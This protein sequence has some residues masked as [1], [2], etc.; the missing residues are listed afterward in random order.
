MMAHGDGRILERERNERSLK[1]LSEYLAAARAPGSADDDGGG[2]PAAAPPSTHHLPFRFVFFV[3]E[4][5]EDGGGLSG[6]APDDDEQAGAAAARP[7]RRVELTLPPPE[8]G[9]GRAGALSPAARRA[10]RRLLAAC[11]VPEPP[12]DAPDDERRRGQVDEEGQEEEGSSAG[13]EPGQG[14]AEWLPLAAEAARRG[15]G[16]GGNGGAPLAGPTAGPDP[17]VRVAN[18]RGA[19]RL[20]RGAAVSFCPRLRASAPPARQAALLH[21]LIEVLRR[22]DEAAAA[23]AEQEDDGG[24]AGSGDHNGLLDLRGLRIVLSASSGPGGLDG[25]GTVWLDAREAAAIEARVFGGGRERGEATPSQQAVAA[26]EALESWGDMLAGIDAEHA[27]GL[28]A[29]ADALRGLEASVARAVGVA[30]VVP[31]AGVA[32]SGGEGVS[33]SYRAFLERLAAHASASGPAQVPVSDVPL[34]VVGA[35][36]GGRDDSSSSS[37]SSAAVGVPLDASPQQAYALL[38][39]QG[40]AAAERRRK[41]AQERAARADLDLRA[42]RA[43]GL[44]RLLRDPC[45]PPTQADAGVRRLLRLREAVASGSP[46]LASALEGMSVRVSDA[47]RYAGTEGSEGSSAVVDVAWD[48]RL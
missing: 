25:A 30:A 33:P 11:G 10:L 6:V 4:E 38:A 32:F 3:P 22:E 2:D 44:R 41:D 28:R 19:L 23:L 35:V 37:S 34:V 8:R 5:E 17:S 39:A 12:A 9:R 43:L 31:A 20:S 18:L 14:L 42:R 46:S 26:D 15:G 27:R 21:A 16:G 7:L 47:C 29:A 45:L 48:A 36:D 40:P 1:L 13:L 24:G